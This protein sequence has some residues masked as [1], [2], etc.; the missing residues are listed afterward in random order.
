MFPK[1]FIKWGSWDTQVRSLPNPS[2]LV[3]WFFEPLEQGDNYSL[4]GGPL[5]SGWI[6]P[7]EIDCNL[8]GLPPRFFPSL[9]QPTEFCLWGYDSQNAMHHCSQLLCLALSFLAEGQGAYGSFTLAASQ[10][11]IQFFGSHRPSVSE[12]GSRLRGRYNMSYCFFQS[13]SG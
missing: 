1:R 8:H 9:T 10:L 7:S 13:G 6:I 3:L 5:S 2:S 4:Q 12:T 11:I